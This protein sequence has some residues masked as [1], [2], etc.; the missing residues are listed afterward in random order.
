MHSLVATYLITGLPLHHHNPMIHL[1]PNTT[2]IAV[3]PYRYPQLVK[4]ELKR[5][6]KDML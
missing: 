6:C 2:S 1:L 4:G 5:Q 3:Q